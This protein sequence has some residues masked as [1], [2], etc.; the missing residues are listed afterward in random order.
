[1]AKTN[2]GTAVKSDDEGGI[3]NKIEQYLGGEIKSAI[4]APKVIS[5]GDSSVYLVTRTRSR[6]SSR[7][8]VY[9]LGRVTRL[10][11]HSREEGGYVLWVL[12][13]NYAGNVRGGIRYSWLIDA[14]DLSYADAIRLMN[15]R[16]GHVAFLLSG[17]VSGR[18]GRVRGN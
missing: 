17:E 9:A 11:G 2:K 7:G 10:D 13:G 18:V 1:M 5:I 3:E 4:D 8:D 6:K 12:R 16:V 14:R 15:R